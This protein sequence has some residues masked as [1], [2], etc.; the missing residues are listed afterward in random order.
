MQLII[1]KMSLHALRDSSLFQI[2]NAKLVS[3]FIYLFDYLECVYN[4]YIWVIILL[5]VLFIFINKNKNV[6]F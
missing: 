5:A 1:V 6:S 4:E 3:L 2:L